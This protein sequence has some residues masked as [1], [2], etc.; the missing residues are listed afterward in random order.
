MD[1]FLSAGG[2]YLLAGASK[3]GK[4]WLSLDLSIAISQGKEFMGKKTKKSTTLYIDLESSEVSLK[5]RLLSMFK[6]GVDL[7][8]WSY[9]HTCSRIGEG[10]EE[11]IS[12]LIEEFG[13]KLLIVD[14]L[15][16][17]RS[18][19][20]KGGTEYRHDYDDIGALKRMAIKYDICIVII[21]HLRKMKDDNDVFNTMT[22]ST[23]LMGASDGSIL[24]ARKRGEDAATI[25]TEGRDIKGDTYAMTWDKETT[26]WKFIG[27]SE[28]VKEVSELEQFKNEPFVIALYKMIEASD[29]EVLLP[30]NVLF[31]KLCF[32]YAEYQPLP[33]NP[34]RLSKELKENVLNF[35]KIGILVSSK[36]TKKN[37]MVSLKRTDTN[38][39]PFWSI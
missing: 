36:R 26:R 38:D 21:T 13:F 12:A 32:D 24:L 14:V 39:N 22:G 25:H 4:T 37:V 1:D 7:S 35:K 31:D 3:M 20:P 19:A 6:S 30:V 11:D 16:K 18:D 23:G 29:G 28:E 8:N 33:L 27:R 17:I 9:L 34:A 10:F 2:V 5:S 15:V